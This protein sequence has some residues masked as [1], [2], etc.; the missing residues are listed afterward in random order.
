[1]ASEA[2]DA[3]AAFSKQINER[4]DLQDKTRGDAFRHLHGKIDGVA[5]EVT[6]IGMKLDTHIEHADERFEA[7][8]KKFSSQ[9]DDEKEALRERNQWQRTFLTVLCS[10]VG[11]LVINWIIQIVRGA[12]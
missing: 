4:L 12:P 9:R 1:M 5:R 2:V 6:G 11:A 8:G 3:I 7:I 10:S